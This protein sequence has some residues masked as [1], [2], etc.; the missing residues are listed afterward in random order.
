MFAT[1]FRSALKQN[2]GSINT[3]NLNQFGSVGLGPN[4]AGGE[5]GD[6]IKDFKQRQAS[7]QIE[8]ENLKLPKM[9]QDGSAP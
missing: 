4:E 3:N 5:L 1:G 7:Q 6:A 8:K 9:T 2:Q